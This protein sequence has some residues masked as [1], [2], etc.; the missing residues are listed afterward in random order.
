MSFDLEG[1]CH[2]PPEALV[3]CNDGYAS[4][5]HQFESRN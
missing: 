5:S 2:G 1:E 4:F 3:R